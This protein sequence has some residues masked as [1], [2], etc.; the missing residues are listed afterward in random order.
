MSSFNHMS[1][2]EWT[3]TLRVLLDRATL[4]PFSRIKHVLESE[5]GR[6]ISEVFDEFD[7]TPIASASIAQVYRA[8]LKSEDGGEWVAVKVQKPSIAVQ[9]PWDLRCYYL[10][11]FCFEKMFDLPVL[12]TYEFTRNSCEKEINFELEAQYSETVAKNFAHHPGVYVPRVYK[13][14]TTKRVLV[15]EWID[16]IKMTDIEGLSQELDAPAA[17]QCVLETFADMIFKYGTV[18]CD[19]HPGNLIVRPHPNPTRKFPQQVVILDH[20]LSVELPDKFRLEYA[21]F[22]RAIFTQDIETLQRITEEWG[23]GDIESFVSMQMMKPYTMRAP[24]HNQQV[25]KEMLLKM[26]LK[27]K[28]HIRTWL[29]RQD[30]IPKQIIFVGRSV[31]LLRSL[32]KLY[33]APVNRINVFASRAVDALATAG[34]LGSI[35]ARCKYWFTLQMLTV[36]HMMS[37]LFVRLVP[38]AHVTLEDVIPDEEKI[39][40]HM[41][42]HMSLGTND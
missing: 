30:K 21:Q 8:R 25:T 15:A 16:G 4:T 17:V 2:P 39:A 31:N 3:D 35:T 42:H 28:D 14:L 18:H 29:L 41:H 13:N 19:P 11:L 32:N 12:W 22:W 5:L 26:Q 33:G 37:M 27:M 10:L 34:S 1:P 24:V 40:Q 23:I 38:G 9:M 6:P 36:Y 7:E 20:G